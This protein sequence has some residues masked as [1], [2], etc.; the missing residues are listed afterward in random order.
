M[1]NGLAVDGWASFGS[2]VV[3][4]GLVDSMSDFIAGMFEDSS[5]GQSSL[6]N[7]DFIARSYRSL[8]CRHVIR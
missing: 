4:L 5:V 7:Q 6:L 2:A 1:A 3:D 8:Q